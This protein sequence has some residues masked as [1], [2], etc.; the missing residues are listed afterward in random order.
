MNKK[1]QCVCVCVCAR[2]HVRVCLCV[3]VRAH[4][5]CAQACIAG[6]QAGGSQDKLG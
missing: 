1:G 4:F 5:L 6:W 3:H 2:A